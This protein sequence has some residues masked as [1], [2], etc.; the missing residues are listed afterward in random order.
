M[1]I[2]NIIGSVYVYILCVYMYVCTYRRL[3]M[4]VLLRNGFQSKSTR[5]YKKQEL[6]DV[7]IIFIHMQYVYVHLQY[8]YM[9][10]QK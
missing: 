10:V 2:L 4:Y 7:T 1:Y 6:A 5:V 3:F 9:H 8:V